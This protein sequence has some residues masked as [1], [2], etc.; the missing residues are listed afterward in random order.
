MNVITT[1]VRRMMMMMLMMSKTSKRIITGVVLLELGHNEVNTLRHWWEKLRWRSQSLRLLML[2]RTSK[3]N[4]DAHHYGG[5]AWRW[6]HWSEHPK[7]E[8]RN[9]CSDRKACGCLDL[10]MATAKTQCAFDTF[11]KSSLLEKRHNPTCYCDCIKN[12]GCHHCLV[13]TYASLSVLYHS[14]AWANLTGDVL[15]TTNPC[16][17]IMFN[18]RGWVIRDVHGLMLAQ[19]VQQSDLRELLESIWRCA[20]H[21]R[22]AAW[23]RAAAQGHQTSNLWC[24]HCEACVCHLQWP[25]NS[26]LQKD[27]QCFACNLRNSAIRSYCQQTVDTDQ[28]E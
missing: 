12:T 8:G 27:I 20:L 3:I 5:V 25:Q 13:W 4:G 1:M 24:R 22:E 15:R 17:P 18:C 10:K 7:D 21:V 14:Q 26:A 9:C 23:V 16:Q 6:P 19:A 11:F 28:T 2:F